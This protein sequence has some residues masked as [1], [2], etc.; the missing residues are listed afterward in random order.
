MTSTGNDRDTP[1]K[2]NAAN[3]AQNRHLANPACS[4]PD[5]APEYEQAL[6]HGRAHTLAWV[7]ETA[8][9]TKAEGEERRVARTTIVWLDHETATTGRG[10]YIV[11]ETQRSGAVR[12]I[13]PLL[14]GGRQVMDELYHST[15]EDR[16]DNDTDLVE[17]LEGL[18]LEGIEDKLTKTAAALA[19]HCS[20][21]TQR[22]SKRQL[23]VREVLTAAN[24]MRSWIEQITS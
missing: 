19:D 24:Q 15:D 17:R 5:I 9:A 23:L 7:W 3:D 12:I 13:G 6:P 14:D 18:V 4:A 1:R 2:R 20:R 22:S 11:F 16:R 8:H 21:N 10:W